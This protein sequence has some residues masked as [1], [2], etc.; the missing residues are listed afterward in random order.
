[1]RKLSDEQIEKIISL[2]KNG[3]SFPEEYRGSLIKHSEQLKKSHGL[4]VNR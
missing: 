3:A 2:L 1:M 4:Y